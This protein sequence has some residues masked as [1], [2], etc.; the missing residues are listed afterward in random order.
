MNMFVMLESMNIAEA[1]CWDHETQTVRVVILG[2][3]EEF[4]NHSTGEL[5]PEAE[6]M[7]NKTWNELDTQEQVVLTDHG[8]ISD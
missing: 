5:T 2:M 8:I 4:V 1:L 6:T 3:C 7:I